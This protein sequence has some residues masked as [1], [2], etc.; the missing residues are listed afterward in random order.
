MSIQVARII[1]ITIGSAR[2]LLLVLLFFALAGGV[3][4]LE[5]GAAALAAEMAAAEATASTWLLILGRN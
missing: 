3:E 4:G 1:E 2:I 5:V